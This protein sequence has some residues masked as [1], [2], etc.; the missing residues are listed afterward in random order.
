MYSVDPHVRDRGA[1]SQDRET[2]KGRNQNQKAPI[3]PNPAGAPHVSQE[4]PRHFPVNAPGARDF[5]WNSPGNSLGH[6]SLVMATRK[7]PAK[8]PRPPRDSPRPPPGISPSLIHIS[9]GDFR[10]AI[11]RPPLQCEPQGEFHGHSV[12]GNIYR[13]S[14]RLPR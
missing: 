10:V 6:I 9:M 8:S 1:V 11:G 2:E 3:R 5:V 13:L 14:I 12:A 4:I 7:F